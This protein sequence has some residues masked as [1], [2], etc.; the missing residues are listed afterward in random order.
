MRYRIAVSLTVYTTIPPLEVVEQETLEVLAGP[1]TSHPSPDMSTVAERIQLVS[2][3][4]DVVAQIQTQPG[5]SLP[6]RTG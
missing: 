6:H 1:S 4:V 3:N 2:D 5:A